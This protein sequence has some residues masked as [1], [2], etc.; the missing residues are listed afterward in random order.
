MQIE[1]VNHASYIVEVKGK[2]LITDP[3]LEF[4]AFNEGWELLSETKFSYEDFK[5]IDYIWF[6][7]EHPDHFVPLVIRKIPENKDWWNE[8]CKANGEKNY[9]DKNE[10]EQQ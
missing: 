2:K 5:D 9:W 4:R 10:K 7:H 8:I 1:F 3:W 6:S